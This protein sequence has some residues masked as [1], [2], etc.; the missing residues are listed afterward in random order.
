[1]QHLRL[2]V[3]LLADAVAAE[4]TH[5]RQAVALG[6]LLDGVADVSQACAGLDL[7]DAQPHGVEGQGRQALGGDGAFADQV[8]AAV[9]A[10]PAVVGD[11][12]DVHIDDVALLERLVVGNAV[13]DHVVHRGAQVAGIGRIAGRLVADGGRHG[14]LLVHALLAQTVD[15]GRG[16]A[17]LDVRGDVVQ[18][19][20]CQTAGLSHASDFFSVFDGNAT[21]IGQLSHWNF[22]RVGE[23][24]ARSALGWALGWAQAR[25]ARAGGRW[26]SP[27]GRH[28]QARVLQR[29]APGKIPGFHES[30]VFPARPH[31]AARL[32]NAFATFLPHHDRPP[33]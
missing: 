22:F 31:S 16:D 2:F 13:A 4:L 18:H 27:T 30:G 1:M 28:L 14:A 5:H 8:H 23:A 25:A 26:P 11:D 12:G 6:V 32:A 24:G 20:G 17:G 7:L 3:E 21:H 9:V 15:L 29:P 33:P 19:F 10:I